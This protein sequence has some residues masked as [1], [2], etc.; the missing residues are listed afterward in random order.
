MDLSFYS[1]LFINI[2]IITLL[3]KNADIISKK[4]GLNKKQDDQTPLVGGLGIFIFFILFNFY[5][6]YFQKQLVIDY[7]FNILILI[8]IIFII[9]F[10]DD[11][12]QLSYIK[13]LI[14]IYLIFVIFLK[15]TNFYIIDQLYF[16]SINKTV[17]LGNF[18]LYITP[19]FIL[20][21]LNSL[22]MADGINGNS[23]I[24]IISYLYLL[25]EN[26]INL[27]LL[28]LSIIIPLILF[29]YFNLRNKIYL[30]DSGI[31]LLSSIIAL[32]VINKYNTKS[33]MISCE[34]IFL[35][36]LIPGLD[37]F[38]LFIL[39]LLKK[40]NPFKG[41]NNHLHHLLLSKYDLK[42]TLL[43]YFILIN[44]PNILYSSFKINILL[45]ILTNIF[46]FIL[47]VLYLQK[48]KKFS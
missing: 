42:Y 10:F 24:I 25:Y 14:F 46:I 32:Y 9:G 44:W 36:F 6:F 8:S 5:L 21:L 13:R 4:I 28:V 7:Q 31:Y 37:M 47:F 20:L 45:L 3:F 22:N 48:L 27:N 40:R 18:A 33:I 43:I 38:R 16:E 39:R 1:F 41:D 2:L 17:L 26:N 11:V 29:L 34:E 35:I 15:F 23:G 12:F 30:G 19:F